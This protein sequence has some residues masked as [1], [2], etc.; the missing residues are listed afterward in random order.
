MEQL[1]RFEM[2]GIKLNRG[3]ERIEANCVELAASEIYAC[4]RRDCPRL[5]ILELKTSSPWR[6]SF[7]LPAQFCGKVRVLGFLI[8]KPVSKLVSHIFH[9]KNTLRNPRI[10]N[11]PI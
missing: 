10:I 2:I 5:P 11:K 3:I 1:G 4:H 8:F 9:S 7:S 6:D